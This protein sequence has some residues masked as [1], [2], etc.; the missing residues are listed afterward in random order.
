MTTPQF[1]SMT[2]LTAYLEA[3]QQ[4]I[5]ALEGELQTLKAGIRPVEAQQQETLALVR[6]ALPQTGLFSRSYFTRAFTVWGHYFV[7][8]LLIAL[9]VGVIYLAILLF[10]ISLLAR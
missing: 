5:T 6:A 10:G 2:D 7:A 1:Q 8:Q 3:Q 4:R 9:G